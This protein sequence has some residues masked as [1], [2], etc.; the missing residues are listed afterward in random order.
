MRARLTLFER[1]AVSSFT[2]NIEYV[3]ESLA[4]KLECNNGLIAIGARFDV[5]E[6]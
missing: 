3:H 1:E 5:E 6:I 2:F 4:L